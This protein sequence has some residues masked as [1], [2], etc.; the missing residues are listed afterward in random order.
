MT[1]VDE[2]GVHLLPLHNAPAFKVAVDGVD[3]VG[4]TTFANSLGEWLGSRG[5]Q[6]I[7]SSVDGF[8]NPQAIRHRL[9]RASP[10]GFYRHSYDHSALRQNLLDPLSPGGSGKYRTS[11][12]DHLTDGAVASAAQEAS[13]DA[14]LIFDGLFLHRPELKRYWDFTIY[15]DAPFEITVPRG[16]ARS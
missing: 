9:G 5:R 14:V 15:L 12:F 2:I 7:R 11:V 8:H 1:V 10:D 16:A 13:E 4:K 3:G 6:V